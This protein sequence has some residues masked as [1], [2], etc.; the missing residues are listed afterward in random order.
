[1]MLAG[2][3]EGLLTETCPTYTVNTVES[4]VMVQ[5]YIKDACSFCSDTWSLCKLKHHFLTW[6]FCIE[7]EKKKDR[8]K[9]KFLSVC[10]SVCLFS[11]PYTSHLSLFLTL[12]CFFLLS[13][14]EQIRLFRS[15][16]CVCGLFNDAFA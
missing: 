9:K 7:L 3:P 2:E 13:N 1:M 16:M 11:F 12:C 15:S 4:L 6:F 10:L 5:I 8:K 14:S